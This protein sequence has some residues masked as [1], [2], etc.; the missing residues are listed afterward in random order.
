MRFLIMLKKELKNTKQ[1]LPFNV[2]TIISP[3]LFLFAF[4]TM[5]SAGITLPVGVYDAGNTNFVEMIK[6]YKTPSGENYLNPEEVSSLEDI[7]HSRGDVFALQNDIEISEDEIRG[8]IF[9]YVNDV[10]A[11]MLKNYNNRLDGLIVEIINENRVKGNVFVEEFTRYKKDIKWSIGFGV[12]IFVLGISLSGLLY[13]M[14][15][16]TNEWENKMNL[17]NRLSPNYKFMSLFSKW[18]SAITKGFISGTIFIVV[19]SVFFKV[20]PKNNVF[21]FILVLFL[22]YGLF[23]FMGMFVGYFVKNTLT[24]FLSSMIISLI[25]WITGGGFG[26]LSYSGTLISWIAKINPATYILELVRYSYFDGNIKYFENVLALLFS[27][28]AFVF[29][30]AIGF[31]IWNN[32]RRLR[33]YLYL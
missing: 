12:S 4:S 8:T 26:P 18:F 7:K 29:T 5:L 24:S 19:L 28:L 10:N 3:L 1:D 13:G 30:F 23:A 16:M 31:I 25:M 6:E 15:T 21:L 9:H 22:S 2:V 32:R 17:I 27:N 11:N 33:D 20:L 14:L